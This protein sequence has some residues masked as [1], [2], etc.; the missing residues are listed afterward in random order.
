[1]TTGSGRHHV[2]APSPSKNPGGQYLKKW[3]GAKRKK[4][5]NRKEERETVLSN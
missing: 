2:Q 1:M 5:E 4:R 3:G